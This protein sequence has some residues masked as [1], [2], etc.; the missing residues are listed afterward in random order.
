MVRVQIVPDCTIASEHGMKSG[1]KR[2][3]AL[4]EKD[5]F[6]RR[7]AASAKRHRY[8]KATNRSAKSLKTA[9]LFP[10]GKRNKASFLAS[11]IHAPDAKTETDAGKRKGDF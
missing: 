9:T 4:P 2:A 10:G 5:R 3:L 6:T 1:Q 8:C 7:P 11:P